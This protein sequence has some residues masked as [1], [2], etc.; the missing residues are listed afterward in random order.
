MS[1]AMSTDYDANAYDILSFLA[2]AV[3]D[4]TAAGI[5]ATFVSTLG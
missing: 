5:Y 4:A 1:W 2:P 3:V